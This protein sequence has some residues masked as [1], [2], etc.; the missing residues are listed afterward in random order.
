[1]R[2]YPSFLI[3][4]PTNQQASKQRESASQLSILVRVKEF[5][6]SVILERELVVDR[7]MEF[8]EEESRMK[9]TLTMS[10][11]RRK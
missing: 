11:K 5:H 8:Q 7:W 9:V 4:K 3:K 6:L 1:M 2:L 10:L